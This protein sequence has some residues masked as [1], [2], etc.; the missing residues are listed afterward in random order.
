ML[1]LFKSYPAVNLLRYSA[2]AL[3]LVVVYAYISNLTTAVFPVAVLILS[4]GAG[5]LLERL[6]MRLFPAAV[7]AL[8]IA[9]ILRLSVFAVVGLL[10]TILDGDSS[11]NAVLDFTFFR[12]DSGF[13][14]LLPAAVY[15]FVMEFLSRRNKHFVPVEVL[16]N[17]IVFGL[18]LWSQGGYNLTLFP[19]PGVLAIFCIAFVIIELMIILLNTSAGKNIFSFL[20]FILPVFLLIL[21]MLF[22]QY[23][24]G[25]SRDGGGLM[26]PTLFRFDFSDYVKLESEISMD[27]DLVLLFRNYGYLNSVYLRRFY[28]SGY[29]PERGFYLQNGP[30][31]P[32]QL[33]SLP[34]RKFEPDVVHYPQ[35]IKSEQEYFIINFDPSSLVAMNYPVETNPLTN[36]QGSSFLRNYRVISESV[37]IPSWELSDAPVLELDPKLYDFYTEFGNDLA[38]KEL[39]EEITQGLVTPYDKVIAIMFYLHDTYYYSLKPGVAE[40]GNQLHHFLFETKKGYC[41]Y[42]AFSMTLMC[43]S[44]G[45]PARVAAGFFIDPQS[46]ILN[47]YPVREDMAHAWV[48]VPFEDFGWVEFDPTTERLAPG[49]DLEFG[50]I[51]SSE[52]SDLVE[53]I[54]TN[55]YMVD[56]EIFPEDADAG[57]ADRFRSVL[58]KIGRLLR[59]NPGWFVLLLYIA[60]LSV[61]HITDVLRRRTKNLQ[62]RMRNN[63][64]RA[65]RLVSAFGCRRADSESILEHAGRAAEGLVPGFKPL[66]EMYLETVF[67]AGTATDTEESAALVC[68][69]FNAGYRRLSAVKRLIIFIFPFIRFREN[70]SYGGSGRVGALFLMMMF[71]AMMSFFSQQQVHA[72]SS[73]DSGMLSDESAGGVEFYLD[74]A[75]R[76]QD[77]ENYEAALKLLTEGISIYPDDW[78][79]KKAAGDLYSDRELYHLA[80][81]QYNLALELNPDNVELL[82][83]RSVDEGLL[84]FDDRSILTL[85]K[86]LLIAPDNYDALADLGWMYFKTFRLAEAEELLLAAIEIYDDSPILYMTLGT[87]YSGLYDYKNAE[88]YY[89]ES[90]DMALDKGWDYFAS[91]SYYNLSLLEHGF[92]NYEKAL[93]YTDRSIE[94]GER[95]PGYIA[96]AEINLG[97]MDFNS[98]YQN[99]QQAFIMDSTPLALMGLA[100]LYSTFGLLDEALSHIKEVVKR[101]DDSWMYYFGVD[102][103]RHRMETDR[104][105]MDIYQGLSYRART[106]PSIGFGRLRNIFN[107]FRYSTL[108]WYHS[109]RYRSA[110]YKV[111]RSNESQGNK[112]DAAWAYF[113]ANEDY[114][115]PAVRY[116][117]QAEQ[118][119]TAVAPA[120]EGSYLLE[121][122]KLLGDPELLSRAVEALDPQWERKFIADALIELVKLNERR[123]NIENEVNL[124][125]QLYQLNPGAFI[126]KGVKFP[127]AL[128]FKAGFFLRQSLKRSGF[129][130]LINNGRNDYRYRLTAADNQNEGVL[131]SVVDTENEKILF[132][133]PLQTYPD[134]PRKVSVFTAELKKR[135]FIITNGKD[136]P[137][138]NTGYPGANST[139]SG[140]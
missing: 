23:S 116:L 127:L 86:I 45:I 126:S 55:D 22:G 80:L 82:Y 32:E 78:K 118:I 87:V 140:S 42:F 119:E 5:Y 48:E 107:R 21:L 114:G 128:D 3:L 121:K 108:S 20:A 51:D 19:H 76:E 122:G 135:L 111:G 93:E 44:L 40:D 7:A 129:T 105:L 138:Q 34:D 77:Y 106:M 10:S 79:L 18:L 35:R 11:A 46:E 91:V 49:E 36:W 30:G 47:V 88:H 12:F 60:G 97:R 25:A 2:D 99:Y 8:A 84:N 43:R 98:A 64:R 100:D 41:S 120:A 9:F 132:Q 62:R 112:L 4:A 104:L 39:A 38:V 74:A 90:I 1:K 6:R 52:Y 103:D 131:F 110:S 117:A 137:V 92:Y 72:Q 31:E 59:L 17:A 85:E 73:G 75:E 96:R 29:K 15:F 113:I 71:A 63:Y 56:A 68:S 130:I 66:A 37:E 16:L 65:L 70:R 139:L 58:N 28:L 89:L 134:T 13:F 33:L 123:G 27:N 50:S 83:S 26:Q 102:P 53:E 95:A 24:E 115:K 67:S 101:D 61:F 81:E 69:S 57:P 124:A 133:I 14:P 109:R 136:V 125:E 94:T 54:F